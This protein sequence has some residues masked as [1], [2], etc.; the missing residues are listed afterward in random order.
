MQRGLKQYGGEMLALD[1]GTFLLPMH[2][3]LIVRFDEHFKTKSSL[4]NRHFFVFDLN[5]SNLFIDKIIGKKYN[6]EKTGYQPVYD[7]LYRYLD[8]IRRKQP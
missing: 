6:L 8:N 3:G 4:L 5:D 2:N 7:D 1:D